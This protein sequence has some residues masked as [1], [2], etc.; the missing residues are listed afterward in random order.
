M[1][2]RFIPASD[3]RYKD[4]C[5]RLSQC[6]AAY[7]FTKEAEKALKT[8]GYNTD[9]SFHQIKLCSHP[10]MKSATLFSANDAS[11]ST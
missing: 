8:P 9:R 4:E 7:I 2:E 1:A 5:K 3:C 10:D 6:F 11:D